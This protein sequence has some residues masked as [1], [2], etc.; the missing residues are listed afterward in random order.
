MVI[1]LVGAAAIAAYVQMTPGASRVADDLRAD[2][3]A[4]SRPSTPSVEVR[5]APR[6]GRSQEPLRMV[7][8]LEGAEVKLAKPVSPTPEGIDDKAHL[9]SETFKAFGIAEGRAL[10]CEVKDKVAIID[11]NAALVE[12]GFGSMEEGN[13]VK[14]LQLAL[15]QFPDVERF[16]LLQ[17]GQPIELGHLDLSEPIVVTRPGAK[18][19]GKAPGSSEG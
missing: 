16:Q 6:H 14:A 9:V 15:G 5:T 17:E 19:E 4:V 3:G 2:K 8:A 13:L 1:A 7:P 12:H 18:E 11:V 10:K